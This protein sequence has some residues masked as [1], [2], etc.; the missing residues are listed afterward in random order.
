MFWYD[1]KNF[2]NEGMRLI[3]FISKFFVSVILI[4]VIGGIIAHLLKMDSVYEKM[5]DNRSELSE[6]G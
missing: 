2:S 4:F 6:K 1:R 5:E 3:F